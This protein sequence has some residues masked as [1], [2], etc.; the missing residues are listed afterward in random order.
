MQQQK[1]SFYKLR[2]R[3]TMEIIHLS[4]PLD[5]EETYPSCVLSIG[6]FD[7]IHLGHRRVVQRGIDKAKEWECTGAVMTFDP[8][9]RE[10]LGKSEHIQHLTPLEDKL[11]IFEKMGVERTYVV[12]FDIAFSAIY[13]QDFVEEFLL[14][15]HVRHVVV[16]FDYTFGHRGKGTA[17]T[18]KSLGQ[19][20]FDVD[21]VGP[22]NRLG[23][24]VSS[25]VIRDY[26]HQGEMKLANQ[27]LGRPYYVEGDVIHGEKR[28]ETI[29]FPTANLRLKKKYFVPKTGVYG[30]NVMINGDVYNGVMNIGIK[31]TFENEK[32]EKSIEVY[33]MNWDGSLYGEEIGVEILFFIRSEQ[34]FSGVDELK[35]QIEQ[36]IRTA[37][38][39]FE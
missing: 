14:P 18:M 4:Y 21:I 1:K 12:H 22:V 27:L 30:V 19:N 26:L 24:K 7:G 33:I 36:D 3:E 16:G 35:R 6:Y 25:T 2:V 29:G 9:P 31:P 15:L 28:G 32:K 17:E 11:S 13:P 37:E 10:V 39:H 34:K 38:Q 23:E 5:R 8:H 20:R